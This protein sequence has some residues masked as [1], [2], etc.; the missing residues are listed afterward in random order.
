LTLAFFTIFMGTAAFFSVFGAVF[1]SAS[2]SFAFGF[3]FIGEAAGALS[4]S[5]EAFA[6]A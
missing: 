4:F 1:F 5:T 3:D 2:G 6:F